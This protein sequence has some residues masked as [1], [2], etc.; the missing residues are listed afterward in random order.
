MKGPEYMSVIAGEVEH[1]VK[2]I[3]IE[4]KYR[5]TEES[6]LQLS[7]LTGNQSFFLSSR[8]HILY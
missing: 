8:T 5:K 3:P 1:I 2:Y 4:T 7:A 6:Y